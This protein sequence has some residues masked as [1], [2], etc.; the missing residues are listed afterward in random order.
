MIFAR[1]CLHQLRRVPVCIVPRSFSSNVAWR[2]IPNFPNYIAS[3]DGQIKNIRRGRQLS[4]H[5]YGFEGV[6]KRPRVTLV[7]RGG[8]V[9]CCFVSRIVLST[10]NPVANQQSLQANHIDGN[11]S[12]NKLE[13]NL[14]RARQNYDVDLRV[15]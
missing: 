10:F 8:K 14:V 15:D 13:K 3:S 12:N 1:R 2:E 7:S 6:Q 5:S 9:H 11:A 4:I